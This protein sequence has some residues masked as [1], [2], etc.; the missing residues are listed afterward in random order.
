MRL[1]PFLMILFIIAFLSGLNSW[2]FFFTS[3]PVVLASRFLVSGFSEA[4]L[5]M[6]IFLKES[7]DSFSSGKDTNLAPAATVII[8]ESPIIIVFPCFIILF[9][10]YIT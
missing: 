6:L 4:G 7:V 2:R 3:L 5:L 8:D 9:P 1:N 10:F